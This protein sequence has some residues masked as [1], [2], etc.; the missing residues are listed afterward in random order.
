[1]NLK[2]IKNSLNEVL[3]MCE[4]NI[5]NI[6]GDL[7]M[8]DVMVVDIDGKKISMTDILNNKKIVY[9]KFVRLDLE[10]HQLI[11]KEKK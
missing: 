2:T 9:G 3:I 6:N 10:E 4:S 5:Y 11:I 8:E 7:L 1:M